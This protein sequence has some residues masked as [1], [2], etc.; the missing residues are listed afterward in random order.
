MGTISLVRTT[1]PQGGIDVENGSAL[2]II[3][4]EKLFEPFERDDDRLSLDES[5][6]ALDYF[7]LNDE[8]KP[9]NI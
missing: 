7:D 6:A 8:G 1:L 3:I 2:R 4:E 9:R 5:G